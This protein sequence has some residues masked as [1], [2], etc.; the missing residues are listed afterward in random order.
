MGEALSLL[1]QGKKAN[2]IY[3]VLILSCFSEMLNIPAS[4]SPWFPY[5]MNSLGK[6]RLGDLTE[7]SHR[8][9]PQSRKIRRRILLSSP[10]FY[11][12]CSHIVI[13]LL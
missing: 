3:F 10:S 4:Q 5:L 13:G 1:K 9:L 7:E 11:D 8:H 12:F 2:L 6:F